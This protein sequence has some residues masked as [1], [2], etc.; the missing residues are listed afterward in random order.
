MANSLTI[1]SKGYGE[2]Y[3]QVYCEQTQNGSDKNSSTIDWTLS[4]I[5][6]SVW[7]DTGPTALVING[8][9]VCSIEF[10]GWEYGKF[11][12]AQGSTSGSITIPHNNDGT[13]KITVEFSTAIYYHAVT[14]YTEEWELDPIPRYAASE[15]SLKSK[16]ETTATINWASD[17]IIDHLWYSINNGTSWV[18]AGAVND[19]SGTYTISG[20]TADTAYKI[21]TRVRSKESQL[22]TDSTPLS[23]TTYDYPHCTDAPDFVIGQAVT[24]KFSNPLKRT[25]SFTMVGNGV[26]IHTWTVKGGAEH[27]GVNDEPAVTNLYASIPNDKNA[28]YSVKV[29]YGTL[30]RTKQGGTYSVDD[31]KCKPIFTDFSYADTSTVANN[32]GNNQVLVKNLSTLS[33]TIAE[34]QKMVARNGAKPDK[35]VISIDTMSETVPYAETGNVSKSIGS[36]AKRGKLRLTVRAFDTRG[37]HAEIH[38]DIMIYDYEKPV[39][40][41]D[42]KRLNNF[43]AQTTLKVNGSFS[44]VTMDNGTDANTVCEACYKYREVGGAWSASIPFETFITN[45]N[46]E[47]ADYSCKDVVLTLD[48]G[49][50]FEFVIITS[51]AMSFNTVP[52][53]VDVGQAIFFVSTNKKTCYVNGKEVVTYEDGNINVATDKGYSVNGKNILINNGSGTVLSAVNDSIVFR[54]NGDIDT[55][56]QGVYDKNGDLY[57]AGNIYSPTITNLNN[58]ITNLNNNKSNIIATQTVEIP[59][60]VLPANGE[61]YDQV[62]N[63]TIKSG[64]KC[65]GVVG[66]QMYGTYYSWCA[67][68]RLTASDT[69]I[70]WSVHNFYGDQTGDLAMKVVLLLM[71]E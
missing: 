18:N 3:M 63:Y 64:Y 68:Q 67:I 43:E 6:D 14:E 35:Y 37:I 28:K 61:K 46:P 13:K 57:V 52:A 16:T 33:V 9:T 26:D 20:L 70:Q 22:T 55:K 59:I 38:K 34:S 21:K 2:R 47:T 45:Y 12:V 15:H 27:E 51:D 40:N 58:S 7:Y 4:A 8:T 53:N 31:S 42:V 25:F 48:N 19:K 62:T 54:P 10:K 41:V 50:A 44:R 60:G 24:I 17:K 30:T 36:I 23:V 5:G 71:Y 69:S 49:K 11:P 29:V 1:K 39:I 32:T 66:Y 65:V 56:N